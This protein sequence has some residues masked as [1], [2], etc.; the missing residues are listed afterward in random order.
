[1]NYKDFNDY[2]LLDCIYSI[3]EDASEILLYK[4]RPLIISIS[5]K[6]IKYCEGGVDLND[7]VQEGMLGLSDAI[8]SFDD[9]KEANFGTY[10]KICIQRKINSLVKSTRRY[11]H[12]FL[13]ESF[14]LEVDDTILN[15]YLIDKNDPS[16]IIEEWE[17]QQEIIKKLYAVLT[18]FER[19]VFNL[20]KDNFNYKEIA[21]IL[22]KD[23][24]SIDNTIQRIKFKLKKIIKE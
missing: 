24:K 5:N 4:Y 2:E 14:A 13:N 15:K 23:P 17:L 18:A 9:N 11:K 12:R 21:E 20:K 1:M 3:N 19:E 6:M 7:L 10:A 16:V 8:N 22:E